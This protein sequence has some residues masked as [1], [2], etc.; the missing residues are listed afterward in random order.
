[1]RLILDDLARAL[2][3]GAKGIFRGGRHPSG[4]LAV[5]LTTIMLVT[6]GSTAVFA[7]ARHVLWPNLPVHEPARLVILGDS[8]ATR[9][10]VNV[11]SSWANVMDWRERL[12][13]VSD[14]AFYNEQINTLALEGPAGGVVT[15]VAR[16]SGNLLAV[17][18]ARMALGTGFEFADTWAEATPV[19]VVSHRFWTSAFRGDPTLVGRTIRLDGFSYVIRGVL[20]P[21]FDLG[22][23]A[24][25]LW[26]PLRLESAQRGTR[27]FRQARVVRA[28]ARL[29]PGASVEQLQA[30]VATL[31]T[32]LAVERPD[33]NA[34]WTTSVTRLTAFLSGEDANATGMYLAAA[35]LLQLLGCANVAALL[36]ARTVERRR[37]HAV[38]SALGA[39]RRHVI[40]AG[41]GEAATLGTLGAVAGVLLAA[42]VLA[43]LDA[44][45]PPGQLPL[46]L[47][48]DGV[49]LLF[50]AATSLI[51]VL[52]FGLWPA[53]RAGR[54]DMA[55][56]LA[57]GSRAVTVSARHL[58]SMQGV[59]LMQV[60]L[61][62]TL[63]LGAGALL[64]GIQALRQVEIGSSTRGVLAFALNAPRSL[65]GDDTVREAMVVQV[66]ERL[67][68]LPAVTAVAAARHEPLSGFGWTSDFTVDAWPAERHGLEVRH[69]QMTTGYFSTLHVPLLEGR[70]FEDTPRSGESFEVVVNEAF[71]RRYFPDRSPLGLGVT[72]N[73]T[74]TDRTRWHRIVGVVGDE[75]MAIRG[76]PQPEIH[77]PLMSD[78]PG[79]PHL[80]VRSSGAPLA[81]LPAVR[82]AVADIDR[83]IAV[84]D[85]RALDDVVDQALAP[86]RFAALLLALFA[87]TAL[88]LAAVAVHGLTVQFVRLRTDEI[89]IRKIL[90][91]TD[92]GIVLTLGRP[93][94]V[95][96]GTGVVAGVTTA[97]WTQG[98]LEAYLA[99]PKPTDATVVVWAMALVVVATAAGTIAPMRRVM[100]VQPAASE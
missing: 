48:F 91:A 88:A 13:S 78:M 52:G 2:A 27:W 58:R 45:R 20:E 84:F 1:M 83:Q 18:G 53:L 47:E 63:A 7:V 28:L 82:A 62:V 4:S 40:A 35:L 56:E 70:L 74:R 22:I 72:F 99:G 95:I 86:E 33:T 32:Q 15:D 67:R 24:V 38:R 25:D 6:A 96:L 71:V 50:V 80:L 9:G 3:G 41:L 97:S 57:S 31:D 60:T 75:R 98:I 30:E 87:A 69:R 34:E 68:A 23:G 29:A 44:V 90:G 11:N 92:A 37:E 89:R 17:V 5:V 100:R 59:L 26:V 19:A 73:R 43:A 46:A 10:L 16:V 61:A 39:G 65:Y 14:V 21:G 49:L 54:V 94:L 36:L 64:Q 51:S 55:A 66:L 81:L 76:A 93:L 79:I 12:Q 8:N 42:G 77:G 85:E